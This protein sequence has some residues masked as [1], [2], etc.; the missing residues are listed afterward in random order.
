MVRERLKELNEHGKRIGR[1]RVSTN[2]GFSCLSGVEALTKEHMQAGPWPLPA[3]FIAQD[4]VLW[5]QRERMCLIYRKLMPQRRALL[6][7][8]MWGR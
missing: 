5:P 6:V 8:L 7:E 4:C 2:T 1:T 3:T